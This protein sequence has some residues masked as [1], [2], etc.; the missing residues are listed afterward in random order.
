MLYNQGWNNDYVR[1]L[2]GDCNTKHLQTE[3]YQMPSKPKVLLFFAGG[4]T[5]GEVAAIRYLN[6]LVG[7]PRQFIIATTHIVNSKQFL[8]SVS[9]NIQNEI[10][11]S[12]IE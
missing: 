9:E 1:L 8:S 6:N 4:I 12:S 5:F 11:R 3:D 7:A 2:A 10:E